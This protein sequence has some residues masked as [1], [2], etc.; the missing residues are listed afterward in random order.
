MPIFQFDKRSCYCLIIAEGRYQVVI[1]EPE[2]KKDYRSPIITRPFMETITLGRI[3]S[4]TFTQ[5]VRPHDFARYLNDLFADELPAG[6]YQFRNV[7]VLG[8]ELCLVEGTTEGFSRQGLSTIKTKQEKMWSLELKKAQVRKFLL[9]QLM[10]PE[11]ILT[12][13]FRFP[14]VDNL[15]VAIGSGPYRSFY[16]SETERPLLIRSG[17][18]LNDVLDQVD[19]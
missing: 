19:W 15:G 14:Y 18:S 17:M 1:R 5:S 16:F 2:N 13:S 12:P 9:K 6:D 4:V 8:H 11:E 7:I 3:F 10:L